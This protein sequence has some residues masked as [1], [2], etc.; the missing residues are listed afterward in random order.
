MTVKTDLS[1]FHSTVIRE[2]NCAMISP[3]VLVRVFICF[4]TVKNKSRTGKKPRYF[5]DGVKMAIIVYVFVIQN[6]VFPL[7]VVVATDVRKCIPHAR[8]NDVYVNILK[9]F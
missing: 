6:D 2:A 4:E 3:A 5:C 7:L 9:I 1:D 8:T